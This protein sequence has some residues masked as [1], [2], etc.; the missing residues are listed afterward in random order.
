MIFAN[1]DPQAR[2]RWRDK[3][4]RIEQEIVNAKQRSSLKGPRT[5]LGRHIPDTM[6]FFVRLSGLYVRGRL[7][8]VNFSVKIWILASQTCLQLLMAIKSCIY[9]TCIL[10]NW[11]STRDNC[12]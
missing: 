8:T 2:K 7:N 10:A 6:N 4:M 5:W 9:L 1:I 11:W 12:A 3:R